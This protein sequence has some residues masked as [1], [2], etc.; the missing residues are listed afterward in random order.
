MPLWL[1][2]VGVP[3]QMPNLGLHGLEAHV[4]WGAALGL[5]YEAS[6]RWVFQASPDESW[7]TGRW[8]A[9]PWK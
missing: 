6:R 5:G 4:V 7:G 1:N 8:E 9:S 3:A 2:L